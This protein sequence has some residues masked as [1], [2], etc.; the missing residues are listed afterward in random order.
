MTHFGV[1]V[2]KDHYEILVG[3]MM[4]EPGAHT[5]QA[6]MNRRSIGICLIGNFDEEEPT[7]LQWILSLRLVRSLMHVAKIPLSSVY[8]HRDFA[9]YKSCPGKLFD[10]EKF[11]LALRDMQVPR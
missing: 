11:K 9:S 3:R 1:E 10:M 7:P 4:D 8:G 6:G 2:I 5:K